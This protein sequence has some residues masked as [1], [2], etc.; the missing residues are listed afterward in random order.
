M[1]RFMFIPSL[2]LRVIPFR[3]S[4]NF[5]L[6]WSSWW[7]TEGSSGDVKWP[8]SWRDICENKLM[9]RWIAC[10]ACSFTPLKTIHKTFY[11]SFLFA[12]ASLIWKWL[13]NSIEKKYR[14]LEKFRFLRS[15]TWGKKTIQDVPMHSRWAFLFHGHTWYTIWIE[16]W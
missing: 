9:I 7:E 1:I 10:E 14:G 5:Q 2:M 8:F 3:S 16:A 11:V 13:I 12:S 15:D 4:S 6:A